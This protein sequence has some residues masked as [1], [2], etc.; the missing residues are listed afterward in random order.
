MRNTAL[1]GRR[2]RGAIAIMFGLTV[3][4]VMGVVG[5]ALDLT[6]VYNRKAELQ[7]LADAT[8]LAAAR[9]LT[10]DAAG[11]SAALTQASAVAA[12][13]AYQ[14]GH[15]PVA[16]SAAA[17][18]FST[19]A[20]TPDAAWM[21]AADAQAAPAGV[22][23]AKVDTAELGAGTRSVS[24][25]FIG[26]VSS[27]LATATT[28]A[29]AV[30]GRASTNVLPL[31]ICAQSTTPAASR[32][33]VS[34]NTAFNEL[35]EY[36]FRRGV[37]YDLMQ[38]NPDST[39][40]EN[41]LIDPLS[42]P[43]V[44]GSAANLSAAVAGPFV[45]SG[46]MP[47]ASVLGGAITVRR[48]FPIDALYNHLNSRMDLYDGNAC[49]PEG[50]PP[51][52]NVKPYAYTAISWMAAAPGAQTAAPW[53]SA[54][55][56]LRTRADPLPGPA[57]NTAAL[58]GP[59]WAYA[60]AVPYAAYAATPAEPAAGYTPFAA[61]AWSSLYTPAP[62]TANSYPSALPTSTPYLAL[63]GVNFLAPAAARQP[64]LARRRVLNVALLS[65]PVAAGAI[66]SVPV[67]AVGRFFMT[68]AAT[69]SS[70]SAEFA[71]TA[72]PAALAGAVELVR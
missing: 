25:V 10:G 55:A 59:L 37:A 34:G 2:Q 64:G 70:I 32:A 58:Y 15:L 31:A 39:T 36:G 22:L 41:F 13:H 45:C 71:G 30:A 65:C 19:A 17:L 63:N 9:A 43:G 48:G 67:L 68:V 46:S 53:T 29:R 40:P 8:A 7:A 4:G 42:P 54:G 66:A 49:T 56:R 52:S 27:A 60:R 33:N 61:S 38:L 11:V 28:S 20:N 51:D 44:T 12:N 3:L 35:V 26:I 62:P 47:M 72:A 5:L 69:G 1:P 14:Y 57:S 6:L 23:F 21:D 16:W 50:A 24:T 18:R